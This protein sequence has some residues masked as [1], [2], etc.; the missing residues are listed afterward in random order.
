MKLPEFEKYSPNRLVLFLVAITFGPPL[1][2][3]LY[4]SSVLLPDRIMR[5]LY[6]SGK[7]SEGVFDIFAMLWIMSSPLIALFFWHLKSVKTYLKNG[8]IRACIAGMLGPGISLVLLVLMESIR[9]GV[10]LI[11]LL[12]YY[13]GSIIALVPVLLVIVVMTWLKSIS[14][15]SVGILGSLSGTLVFYILTSFLEAYSFLILYGPINYV[16]ALCIC[17]FCSVI[18]FQASIMLS[19][20][21]GRRNTQS[22]VK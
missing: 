21:N 5:E 3:V 9:E 8:T 7:L 6:G 14:K 12:A 10:Y 18:C 22:A 20:K 15:I 19:G 13:F 4:F 2:T 16:L 17:F 11:T 1:G